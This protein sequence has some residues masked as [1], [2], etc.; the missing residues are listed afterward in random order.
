V[1]VVTD[2]DWAFHAD[3]AAVLAALGTRRHAASLAMYFGAAAYAELSALAALPLAAGASSPRVLI[4]PGIMGSRLGGSRRP[5][6]PS[7]IVWVDPQSIAAGGLMDLALP[8]GRAL[9]PQGVLLFAYAKLLL[10]L[11]LRGFDAAMHPYDWRL[12]LDELGAAL[13]ARLRAEDRPVALVAHSMGGLVARMAMRELPRRLVRRLILVGTPNFG[14]YSPLQALRGTY[15]FVRK[16]ATLDPAHSPEELAAR[17]FHSFPGLYQLLPDDIPTRWPADG[18]PLDPAL[19]GRIRAIRAR[20]APPDGRMLQIL[21]VG[22]RTIQAVRRTAAGF[23]YQAGLR[24]DGSVPLAL[25]ALPKLRSFYVDEQHARLLANDDVIRAVIDLLRRGRT[26]ALPTRWRCRDASIE[27]IDD[28]ALRASAE[29]KIDW[30]GL[31]LEE[32]A[33]L[34]AEINH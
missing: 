24:G 2:A 13:A 29:T 33:A 21:G 17:V 12:G 34:M 27:R 7:G 32:R 20:L 16:M 5:S 1:P 28:A 15:P 9:Q 25:A 8:A 30:N 4:L 6:R 26:T 31:S 14:A 11:R 19:H 22:R 10:K 18:P 3:D 23:E